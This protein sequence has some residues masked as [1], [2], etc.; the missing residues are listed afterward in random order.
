MRAVNVKTPIV[1]A[2]IDRRLKEDLRAPATVN[3]ELEILGRA[4][5]LAVRREVL[6]R[7]PDFPK[8]PDNNVCEGFFER[9]VAHLPN[10]LKDFSSFDEMDSSL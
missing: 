10:Y 7:T 9:V 8:L 6:A 3:R 1:E 4:F 2:Y 5:R